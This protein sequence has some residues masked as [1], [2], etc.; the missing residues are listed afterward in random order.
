MLPKSVNS[1]DTNSRVIIIKDGGLQVNKGLKSGET[2]KKATN[3]VLGN[4]D[5]IISPT[6]SYDQQGFIYKI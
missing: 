4:K 5:C 2:G 3:C 1:Q 6:H